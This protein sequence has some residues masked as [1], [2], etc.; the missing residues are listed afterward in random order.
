MSR[1]LEGLSREEKIRLISALQEKRRR[2]VNRLP[3]F[4]PHPGQERVI[5]SKAIERYVWSGNAYG[6]SAL[7]VNELH[8][9]ATG[10]NPVTGEHTPVP[11]KIILMLDAPEKID[12]IISEYRKWAPLEPEQL[13]KRGKAYTSF[14][15][16]SNGSTIHVLTHQVEPL[17][18]EGWN[19]TALFGDEPMPQNVY[20]ALTR[21]LRVK[22][23][24][25]R[26][27]LTGTPI[28]AAW[29]RSDIYEP[30]K[31]GKLPHVE[32][33]FGESEENKSNLEEGWL[34]RFS[35][36]LSPKE[37]EIRLKGQFF[38]LDGLALAHLFRN[39]THTI[40]RDDLRWSKDWP[41]VL[42]VDPHPSKKNCAVLLGCDPNNNLYVLKEFGARQIAR[43]F[44]QELI[45]EAWFD[46][47]R[48]IDIVCDSLGNTDSTSGEGY[49]KF[50]DVCNEVL[51]KRGLRMRATTC[52]DKSDEDFISRIQDALVLPGQP[53]ANGDYIPKLRFVSDCVQSIDDVRRVE[54][55]IDK[56]TRLNKPKLDIRKRD[57]LACIKYA[58]ASKLFFEKPT[59]M[60]PHYVS[61]PVYGFKRTGKLDKYKRRPFGRSRATAPKDDD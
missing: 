41:T 59:R 56:Q 9:C 32:C 24:P 61:R 16:Y 48:V 31:E 46:D 8:W 20:I 23:R 50:I 10:Y 27:L 29:M 15:S 11:Q 43:Q 44:I 4:K 3:Q 30:W 53:D 45:D 36:K 55:F 17:K 25:G 14:I 54:W 47:Y 1:S 12:E 26:V 22:G 49:R 42:A 2:E 28:T 7:L 52:D 58:L 38:D 6:K 19:F 18:C 40:A 5:R 60:R 35:A 57:F 33:F 21:G 37:R 13:H 34:E 39:Q 51:S